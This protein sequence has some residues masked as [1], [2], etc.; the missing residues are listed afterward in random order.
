VKRMF[1]LWWN[2]VVAWGVGLSVEVRC[3]EGEAPYVLFEWTYFCVFFVFHV[4]KR[5]I[6]H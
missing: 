3:V 4:Y 2:A 1:Y 5:A 6:L